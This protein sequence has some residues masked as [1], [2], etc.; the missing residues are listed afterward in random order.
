MKYGE[1]NGGLMLKVKGQGHVLNV[2]Q[3]LK[4]DIFFYL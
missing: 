1:S 2:G 3:V 4:M